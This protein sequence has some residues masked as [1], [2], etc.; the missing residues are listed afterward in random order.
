MKLTPA[1][2]TEFPALYE[3]LAE[4]F[5]ENERRDRADAL[6]LLDRT[7]YRLLR[8][9]EGGKRVGLFSLFDLGDFLFIEHFLTLPEFR[10][11]GLG[12]M[13]LSLLA[14]RPLVLE[15]ERPDTP[16]AERRLAFYGRNGFFINPLDY[17]QPP[18]RKTDA[19]TPMLLLSSPTPLCDPLRAVKAIYQTVYRI[20]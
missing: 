16:M 1:N 3:A 4:A 15:A 8:I 11:R 10:N 6:A 17:A 2:S 13:A 9:E 5:P 20:S 18:Y 19:P 14:T 7:D 12:A